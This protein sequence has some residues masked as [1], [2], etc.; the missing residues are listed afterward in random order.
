MSEHYNNFYSR[1]NYNYDLSKESWYIGGRFIVQNLSGGYHGIMKQYWEKYLDT[2]QPLDV[3]LV[4]ENNKV[5]KQ[6]NDI[7]PYWNIKTIDL[8]YELTSEKPDII[9]DICSNDNPLVNYKFDLIINQATLEHLYN[10]FRAMENLCISLKQNGYIVNHTHP[11][12]LMYHSYP[13]DYF[14]FMIDWWYDLPKYINHI[15]LNEVCMIENAHV[16]SVYKKT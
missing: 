16:F 3:L 6:F 5:K 2:T 15:E 14:R 13:R 11:P 10:P 12:D 1:N 4:S 7:Y 8:Y 9:G